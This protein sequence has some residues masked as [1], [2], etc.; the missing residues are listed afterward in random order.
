MIHTV[1][2]HPHKSK[3]LFIRFIQ[4]KLNY[5]TPALNKKKKIY[6]NKNIKHKKY[7]TFYKTLHVVSRSFIL[8]VSLIFSLNLVHLL[9]S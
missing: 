8:F 1:Q 6:V 9:Y 3:E 5:K 7:E 2:I 4:N